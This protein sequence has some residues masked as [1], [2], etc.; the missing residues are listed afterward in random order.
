MIDFPKN[1]EESEAEE[2]EVFQGIHVYSPQ[3]TQSIFQRFKAVAVHLFTGQDQKAEQQLNGRIHALQNTANQVL[4]ALN[5]IKAELASEEDPDLI[6]SLDA[7]VKPIVRDVERLQRK[8]AHPNSLAEQEDAAEHYSAWIERAQPWVHFLSTNLKD[9]KA[10]I[11]AVVKHTIIASEEMVK[12]DLQVIKDYQ[13]HKLAELATNNS[14][15]SQ[16]Q[17]RLDIALSKHLADLSRLQRSEPA[18]VEDIGLKEL[19]VWKERVETLREKLYNKSLEIVDD[20]FRDIHPILESKEEH[21][22]V[23]LNLNRMAELE[24]D[25]LQ[26][27][28]DLRKHVLDEEDINARLEQY[29]KEINHF[30]KDL[31]E[32][33]ELKERFLKAKHDL[34]VIREN[35]LKFG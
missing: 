29:E 17:K 31:K 10:I 22:R 12:R 2:D 28:R 8:S 35:M 16:L 5:Q 26:L 33:P 1:P 32:T 24:E 21:D 7:V 3:E 4:T 11:N 34:E 23:L 14:D 6:N 13:N 27:Q 9:R 15:R 30:S 25:I 20:I 18:K 19:E